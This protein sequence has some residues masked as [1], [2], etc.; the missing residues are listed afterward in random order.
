MKRALL[1]KFEAKR[2]ELICDLFSFVNSNPNKEIHLG[3][4]LS[5]IKNENQTI[6]ISNYIK[7]MI[8]GDDL[9]VSTEDFDGDYLDGIEMFTMDEIY[10]IIENL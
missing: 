3:F 4:K 5:R 10:A 8:V 2:G 6:S 7:I 1:N 9:L